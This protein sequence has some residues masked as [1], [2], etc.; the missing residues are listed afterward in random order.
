MTEC[1]L[2]KR[3]EKNFSELG[4]LNQDATEAT[5]MLYDAYVRANGD[6]ADPQKY[7]ALAHALQ[8]VRSGGLASYAAGR[9]FIAGTRF[10]T[11]YAKLAN[12]YD[13]L[14]HGDVAAFFRSLDL[15]ARGSPPTMQR[16][17]IDFWQDVDCDAD[18]TALC[19]E[20]LKR[21]ELAMMQHQ[22][23]YLLQFLYAH[24]YN[25]NA[26]GSQYLN[27]WLARSELQSLWRWDPGAVVEV[28]DFFITQRKLK[29]EETG[30]RTNT[31]LMMR[32]L[33]ALSAEARR[34]GKSL[35]HHDRP[36]ELIQGY[37]RPDGRTWPG[38]G[39]GIAIYFNFL[40]KTPTAPPSDAALHAVL[41]GHSDSRRLADQ[42]AA[43][44]RS[45]QRSGGT[46]K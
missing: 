14:G 1:S 12:V 29:V 42:V 32:E 22:R 43:L 25:L 2:S 15:A 30:E 21:S 13:K 45:V 44:A 9:S 23:R 5:L 33:L 20:E 10:W 11:P 24:F 41:A 40:L 31:L 38:V 46:K 4:G 27:D 6:C 18:P 7:L 19:A 17:P 28:L 35:A 36:A 26:E 34:S 37:L 3:L 39:E 16:S 8:R